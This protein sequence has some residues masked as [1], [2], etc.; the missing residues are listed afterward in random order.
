VA[1]RRADSEAEKEGGAEEEGEA[2]VSLPME[3]APSSAPSSFS[4]GRS[5]RRVGLT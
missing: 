5:W 4:R 1:V 3:K 2:Q